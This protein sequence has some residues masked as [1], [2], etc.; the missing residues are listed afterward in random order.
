M[1][2][3]L[4]API[5]APRLGVEVYEAMAAAIRE[6]GHELLSEHPVGRGG[7]FQEDGLSE[8]AIFYRDVEWL[9][10]AQLLVAEV[11]TPSTG[12]GWEIAYMLARGRPVICVCQEAARRSLS[13]MVAGNPNPFQRLIFYRDAADLRARLVKELTL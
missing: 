7:D 2:V 10:A 8:G 5:R 11:S 1:K 12:V 4:A 6:A 3:Y 9:N 13:A